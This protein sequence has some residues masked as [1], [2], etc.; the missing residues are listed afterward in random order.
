MAAKVGFIGA[1]NMGF[2]LISGLIEKSV[3][4]AAQ[5]AVYDAGEAALARAAAAGCMTCGSAEELAKSSEIVLA[6]IKPQVAPSVFEQVGPYL[7]GKL[8]VSIVAGTDTASIKSYLGNDAVRVLRIM[9]NTPAMVGEGVFGMNA[10]SDAL[11]D[12]KQLVESWLKNLGITVW[13]GENL[14]PV[15]TSLPGGG[16]AFVAMFVE[17]MADGGVLG[18]LRRDDAI[19]IAAQTVL[20][21]ARL[22]LEKNIHPAVLKDMVCSPAGTTIEGVAALEEGAFRSTV[23]SAV[24]AA[25]IKADSEGLVNQLRNL[26]NTQ[27]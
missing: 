23:M 8:L 19:R 12:E 10:D 26:F 22:M 27:L 5:I 9:P 13:I 21:S 4:D 15:I 24:E 16:P 3:L 20:G 17:A 25:M 2:A 6:A 18:G 14:F 11:P 1:G 7:S